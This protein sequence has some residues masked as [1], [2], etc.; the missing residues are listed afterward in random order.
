ML[1]SILMCKTFEISIQ[2]NSRCFAF[3][4]LC[5]IEIFWKW[6]EVY[7]FEVISVDFVQ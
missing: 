2:D 3:A 7:A 4:R 1:I 6:S 5:S